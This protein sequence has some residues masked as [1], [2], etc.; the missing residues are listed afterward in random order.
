[1]MIPKPQNV[2]TRSSVRPQR[3]TPSPAIANGADAQKRAQRD[4]DQKGETGE[5]RSASLREA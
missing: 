2:M 1:M 4:G 5:A 3:P